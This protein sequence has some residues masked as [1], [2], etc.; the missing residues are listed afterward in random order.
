MI[1]LVG[2]L[3]CFLN[4]SKAAKRMAE[5][6]LQMSAEYSTKLAEGQQRID[7]ALSEWERARRVVQ[8]FEREQLRDV[9]A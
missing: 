6:T 1:L 2:A 4:S 9:V 5:S 7:A 3:F 8:E